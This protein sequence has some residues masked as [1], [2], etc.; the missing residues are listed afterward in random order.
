MTQQRTPD[1]SDNIQREIE[2]ILRRKQF[3]EGPPPAPRPRPAPPSGGGLGRLRPQSPKQVM[4]AGGILLLLHFL[5]LA[6]MFGLGSLPLTVGLI[7]LGFGFV[8]YLIRPIGGTGR[9]WRGE[10][11]ELPEDRAWT[12]RLYRLIY[13][14]N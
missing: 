9:Y 7:L 14:G 10:R 12:A 1:D 13:R 8:T 11:I 2:D 6:R 4:I 3:G 5:G